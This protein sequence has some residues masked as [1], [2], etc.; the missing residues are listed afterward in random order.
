MRKIAIR[1]LLLV[2]FFSGIQ[3]LCAQKKSKN[4]PRL[5]RMEVA[6]GNTDN[7]HMV[8]MGQNGVLVFYETTRLDEEG[9]RLW[10]FALFDT[11]LKQQWLRPVP[12][13]DN[14]YYINQKQQGENA[15]FV[16]RNTSTVKKGAG[17][18]DILVYNMK[19]QS[20]RSVRGTMPLKASIADF[21]VSGNTL[22]M[23][24]DLENKK[25]DALFVNTLTGAIKVVHITSPESP[26]FDGLFTNRSNGNLVAVTAASDTKT[27]VKNVVYNFRPDGTLVQKVNL[28]FF[29][30]MSRL[31]EF[32]LAE[33]TGNDLKFFGAY[34]LAMKSGIF[35]GNNDKE[36]PTTEGFFYL[37]IKNGKQAQLQQFNFLD[38]KNIPGTFTQSEYHRSKGRKGSPDKQNGT[39]SLLNITHPAVEKIPEGYLLYADA[40]VPY[41]KTESH[42]DYDF[43][44]NMY[45]T[46]YRVF[47]GYQFYD[48]ILAGFSGDGKMLWNNDFPLQNILSY[49]IENKA[50][51]YPDSALITVAYV[52]GGKII[53]QDLYRDKKLD[54]RETVS[55]ASRFSRDRPV[56]A[57]ESKIIHWYGHYF[58]VYGY[59]Q[60]KNRALQNQP[61][62]TV[63]YVNKVT[64]Q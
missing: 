4:S 61:L 58:L 64:F 13:T 3:F 46:D 24:L 47:A 31:G 28:S 59:Q 40:Y 39:M 12:L 54:T 50:L 15:C 43:Y 26:Y 5:I 37:H 57:G 38:F 53:T 8:P 48:V 27:A 7:F 51:V 18:Y 10:Y 2:V 1:L 14:L 52:S 29:D 30:P 35:G 9:K 20:F 32:S 33:A 42:L 23:G 63:F 55:I 62:R 36:N 21:A 25:A 44:G 41:Y 22:L 19:K 45:P 56:G 16:F 6:S 11:H 49:R 34:H 60:L 17:F